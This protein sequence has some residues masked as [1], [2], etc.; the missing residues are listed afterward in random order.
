MAADKFTRMA[1]SI[2][3][4]Y[5]PET[6]TYIRGLLKAWGLLDD[7]ITVEIQ[8]T[9]EQLFV[10]TALGKNLDRL[11]SNVGVTRVAE[12]G[13]EDKDFRRLIPILSFYPKQVRQ[14]IIALLDVFWGESF[15]RPN[16]SSGNTETYD[17]GPEVALTGTLTFKKDELLVKGVGTNFL[18]EIQPGDY[19]KPSA[20]SGLLYAKVSGV[21]DNNTLQLSIAWAN[22][23]IVNTPGQLGPV[24]TLEYRVDDLTTK[25]IRFIPNAFEDLTAVT[26]EE[27]VNFI[28]STLEHKTLITAS[29]FSDPIAGSKLNIRTN[30]PGLR[31]SIQILGGTANAPLLLNF[32]LDLQ[33][34]TRIKVVEV[35]PN[36]IV[37]Q[38]PSSVP[39]LRRTLKGAAHPRE[40]KATIVSNRELFDFSGIGPTSTLTLTVD[41]SP[42]TVTFTNATDFADPSA[43]TALEV[44]DVI[45]NQLM[46]LN[47]SAGNQGND[48]KRVAL[49]TTE[50]SSEYQ[51]TGGTANTVL[52]FTTVLQEDPDLLDA[53]FPSPYLFD[54]VGQ[55]FT[56]TG[57]SSELSVGVVAGDV[58]STLNLVDASDFPN[59]SGKFMLDFGRSNQEGPISYNSRP[60]NSTLLI[61]ASYEFQKDHAAGRK[62]NLVIDKPSIPRITG[63]DY[64]FTV[65]GTE[66]AREAAQELIKKLIAS[67]VVVRFIIDFPEFL[68]ICTCRD[69]G[70]SESP[71]YIGSRSGLG[72]LVF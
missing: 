67:G 31:G 22:D 5:K 60:N 33:T 7:Q 14:T 27:L 68:F 42:Y 66:Q 35:N 36:E 23:T 56:V 37:I 1:R 43:V 8:N 15:T 28:N 64:P 17:F 44:V 3:N 24:Q 54:P 16:I 50:G 26:L 49:N 11:G 19:I 9:K 55:L 48:P 10:A 65:T 29:I 51:I 70:P 32:A 63:E 45:N 57:T 21:L 62:I 41:G 40:S 46:F 30:T 20:A 4:L 39:V 47:A 25:T 2:P 71:N 61:D 6:N 38:I 53:T 13:I 52:G 59:S 72:P 12:L 18:A 69:C 34:E 58:T